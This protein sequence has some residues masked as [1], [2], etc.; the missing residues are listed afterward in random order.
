LFPTP[1]DARYIERLLIFVVYEWVNP[2]PWRHD[3]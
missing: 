1:L 2:S 3:F